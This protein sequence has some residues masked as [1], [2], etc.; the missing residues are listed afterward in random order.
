MVGIT[1]PFKM[2][3]R[4]VISG[5]S[6]LYVY[7]SYELNSNIF[8]CNDFCIYCLGSITVRNHLTSYFLMKKIEKFIQ[9][10]NRYVFQSNLQARYKST[11]FFLYTLIGYSKNTKW[12]SFLCLSLTYLEQ[13]NPFGEAKLAMVNFPSWGKLITNIDGITDVF[14]AYG[15]ADTPPPLS[16]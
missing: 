16:P 9:I 2:F 13:K 5:I 6:H 8:L 10:Y 11:R 3:A 7:L 15:K 14:L 1:Q 4:R 12:K